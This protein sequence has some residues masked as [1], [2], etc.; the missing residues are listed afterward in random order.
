MRVPYIHQTNGRIERLNRTIQTALK[1]IYRKCPM[2]KKI[3]ESINIYNKSF[4][5]AIGMTPIEALLAKNRDKALESTNK[6]SKKF[7][8]SK[9]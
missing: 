2:S 5:R 3:I 9:N 8:K 7:M 4:H 1:K 6:Y